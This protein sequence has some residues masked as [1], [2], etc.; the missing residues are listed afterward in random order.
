MNY[1][2]SFFTL[3]QGGLSVG[4]CLPVSGAVNKA[5]ILL[6]YNQKYVNLQALSGCSAVRLARHV[7]DVE[8]GSSNLPIPTK[9]K[10]PVTK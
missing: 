2:Y 4:F 6:P 5:K 9:Q 3:L 7:R 10:R 8:A 1:G